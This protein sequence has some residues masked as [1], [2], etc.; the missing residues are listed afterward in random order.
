MSTNQPE[1]YQKIFGALIGNPNIGEIRARLFTKEGFGDVRTGI[2]LCIV[3]KKEGDRLLVGLDEIKE[4]LAQIEGIGNPVELK[5]HYLKYV[6]HAPYGSG[7]VRDI[8]V[9]SDEP[10]F[11]TLL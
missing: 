9:V 11:G 1:L 7:Y 5:E 8:V 4:Q 2:E 6:K 3:P 10:Q